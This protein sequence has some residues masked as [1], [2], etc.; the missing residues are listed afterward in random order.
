MAKTINSALEKV[1]G[2]LTPIRLLTLAYLKHQ[3]SFFLPDG[4]PETFREPSG[5]HVK[6]QLPCTLPVRLPEPF[7]ELP[8]LQ[9]NQKG[10][11][12]LPVSFRSASGFLPEASGTRL[13]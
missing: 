12:S 8:E 11:V 6:Q 13:D 10:R 7:R 4:L 9:Q 5:T 2:R 3:M 1:H